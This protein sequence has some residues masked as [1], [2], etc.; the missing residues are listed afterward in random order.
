MADAN[1]NPEVDI[2]LDD[3]K[4]TEVKVEETKQEESKDPNLNVGEVDLGYTTHD[5]EQ[6]KE[7]VAV[8][9]VV[10]QPAEDKTF[11]NERETKLDRTTRT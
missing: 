2:D 5:K 8:E 7:D 6:P 10:E 9:E 4:E 1:K 11:E 3:V